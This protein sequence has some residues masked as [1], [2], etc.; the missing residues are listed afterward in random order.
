QASAAVPS[1]RAPDLPR[2]GM[3]T[4]SLPAA[5]RRGLQDARPADLAAEDGEP[6]GGLHIRASIGGVAFGPGLR[7]ATGPRVGRGA[8]AALADAASHG[9]DEPR[10]HRLRE[11]DAL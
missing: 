6:A 9:F 4:G 11:P 5:R 7:A 2:C 8:S 1:A 3:G 10:R